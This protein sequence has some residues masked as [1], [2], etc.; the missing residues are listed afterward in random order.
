MI[1]NFNISKLKLLLVTLFVGLIFAASDEI[2]Q[3]FVPGR[4]ASIY[5]FIA[6]AIGILI[7]LLLFEKIKKMLD[8][9]FKKLNIFSK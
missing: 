6:D 7:S 8:S 9:I 1:G 4:T 3:S 2:H 5:D